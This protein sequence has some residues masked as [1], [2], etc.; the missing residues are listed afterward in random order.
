MPVLLPLG[1]VVPAGDLRRR[2]LL[3]FA[4]LHELPFRFE[5]M[6][7]AATAREAPG[8]WLG[9]AILGLT[10]LGQTLGAEPQYLEEIIARLPTVLNGRG[11][12][13]PVHPPGTADENQVGGHNSLLRGLGEYFLWKNDPRALAVIR[14]VVANLMLPTRGLYAA[15]P[16]HKLAQ[17]AE[18]RP[19]G[20]TVKNDGAW[21]GLS[22]DIGTIFFTLDGLTQAYTIDPTPELR[23]LIETMIARYTQLDPLKLGAQTHVTL[24]ALRGIFRWWQ[25]VAARPELLAL[26]QERYRIY[27]EHAETEHYANYN[28]FGRPEWTE[29]CGV[30]DSFLL[31]V[32]LWR[33]TGAG[34][35]LATAHRIYYNA[36]CYAQRPNGGFGCDLCVGTESRVHLAPHPKIF[37]AP[38]CCSM[39]GAEGLVCAGLANCALDAATGEIW[40]LFYFSGDYTLRFADGELTLRCTSDYPQ[41]G[42]VTWRV[43]RSSVRRARPWHFFVPPNVAADTLALT[44][45]GRGVGLREAAGF[46]SASLSLATGDGLALSFPLA[47]RVQQPG[48]PAV[49]SGYHR[50]SH[51]P[52]LLGA[53]QLEVVVLQAGDEFQAL[54]RGRYQCRRTG[55][56]LQPLDDVTYRPEAEARGHHTQ[57]LFPD[58]PA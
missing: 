38:W 40:Q 50:F 27:R 23:A 46:G 25:E 24:S 28:W 58:G 7:T 55:T 5:A 26:V 3:N 37:E 17:L 52:L 54:G 30:V 21:I 39:R 19:I 31:A 42:Q 2:T 11:Y 15:Y 49:P 12:I 29:A 6:V 45:N 33:A 51:G 34:D 44:H 22:T 57:L 18:G 13:G 48:H 43:L 10:L 4:R 35:Y 14:S 1:D 20:L 32:Q 36:L 53:E 41:D 56:L 8:D 16:D 47:L 9:R